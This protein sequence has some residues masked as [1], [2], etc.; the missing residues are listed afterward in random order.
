MLSDD[1]KVHTGFGLTPRVTHTS[2][3]KNWG[4]IG[5]S[6]RIYV[7]KSF[8]QNGGFASMDTVIDRVENEY[9]IIQVVD[10]QSWMAGF[11]KFVGEWKTTELEKDK[12]LVEYQYTLFANKP[13]FYLL[14]WAFA[15]LFWPI[16]M[17]RVLNYIK[18]M[19][20]NK[21]PYLYD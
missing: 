8:T 9:W 1:T 3:D 14:N 20:Y 5:S 19:A 7:E 15:K 6:K 12:I 16:Y 4:Q 17:K 11:Y 13:C 21:E 10:F 18:L 2:D